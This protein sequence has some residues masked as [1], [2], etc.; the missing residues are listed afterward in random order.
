MPN[1]GI[2]IRQRL[3]YLYS[4]EPIFDLVDFFV[5]A[6]PIYCFKIQNLTFPT[7][8]WFHTKNKCSGCA[9]HLNDTVYHYK[10]KQIYLHQSISFE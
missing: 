10:I 6:D 4:E 8:I 5:S 9:V 2:N 3:C 1:V 7:N